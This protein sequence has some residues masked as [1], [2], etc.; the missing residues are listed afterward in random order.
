MQ[1]TKLTI[2]K[3]KK[4]IC[5]FFSNV[6]KKLLEWR[7]KKFL[8]KSHNDHQQFLPEIL[9]EFVQQF[10]DDFFF[11]V[12]A[13]AIPSNN[14]SEIHEEGSV[15]FSKTFLYCSFQSLF[16]VVLRNYFSDF[17]DSKKENPQKAP[18]Q[19]LR[20]NPTR[21]SSSTSFFGDPSENPLKVHSVLFHV[22][23]Q[24]LL[25]KS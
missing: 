24:K 18:P 9:L 1:P 12:I 8:K 20:R 25:F 10:F 5:F 2:T 13:F 11:P 23:L 6:S 19:I 14:Y 3:E 4:N 21:K 22:F 17:W 15:R 7:L 16:S